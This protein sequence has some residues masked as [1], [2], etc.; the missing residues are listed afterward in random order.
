MITFS[1]IVNFLYD[2]QDVDNDIRYLLKTGEF[3]PAYENIVREFLS[4]E[5]ENCKQQI[6]DE[7]FHLNVFNQGTMSEDALRKTPEEITPLLDRLGFDTTR[8]FSWPEKSVKYAF[9]RLACHWSMIRIVPLE[10]S[11]R[12]PCL[13]SKQI[14]NKAEQ[15]IMA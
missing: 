4:L 8:S 1:D 12:K 13:H 5:I 2:D 7:N 15:F 9:Q 10:G 11:S 6:N 14:S 3:K